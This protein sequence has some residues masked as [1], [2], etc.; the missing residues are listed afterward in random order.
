MIQKKICLLGSFAVG[1][2]SL[3]QRYVH[4][5]FSD[6]YH[7]TVGVKI[8]KKL[9]RVDE[10]DLNLMIWDIAGED[11]FSTIRP[12]YL[13]GL[14]GCVIVIDGTRQNSFD[15]ALSVY[16][17][18]MDTV[19]DLSVVFALNKSDMKAEWVLGSEHIQT[20][21]RLGHP[22]LETSAKQDTG[23]EEMFV[24]LA[25]QLVRK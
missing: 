6:K 13:R 16:Q 21:M 4:T 18:A 14:A 15:T 3:V 10:T 2:T 8:D 23:V 12:T 5:L 20:L 7:T 25:Q 17:R 1:K 19:A 22:F 9:I 11:D 24:A